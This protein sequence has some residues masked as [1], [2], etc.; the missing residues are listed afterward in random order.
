[1][2]IS[3]VCRFTTPRRDGSRGALVPRRGVDCTWPREMSVRLRLVN[4]LVCL[5]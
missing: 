5:G 1:M 2:A 3:R 4:S